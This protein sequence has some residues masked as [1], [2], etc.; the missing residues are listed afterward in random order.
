LGGDVL[1]RLERGLRGAYER[2]SSLGVIVG[3]VSRYGEVRVQHGAR[4]EFEVDPEVYYSGGPSSLHRVGDYLVVVDPK[5]GHAALLRVVEIVRRD[6]LAELGVEP[7]VSGY[8][9]ALEPRG[10]LTRTTIVGELLVEMDPETGEVVPA[11]TSIEPQAPVVDPKPEVLARLLDLPA[12]GVPL[13]ALATPGSLVKG[14]SVPVRLPLK[15][16]LQH[17][18][19]LGTTG[20]GKTTLLKNMIASLYSLQARSARPVVV[21]ADMN[22]DF[23]QLP[24]PPR[25]VEE[26]PQAEAVVRSRIYRGV[27]PPRALH[28]VVPVTIYDVEEAMANVEDPYDQ[29]SLWSWFAS[30]YYRYSILPL[31]GVEPGPWRLKARGGAVAL[32]SEVPAGFRLRLVP[33]SIDT[34][35]MESDR[36][37][38]LM[39]GLTPFARELLR[40][41][42]ERVRRKLDGYA[43][44]LQAL[45]VAATVEL[46]YTLSRGRID[47]EE[48]I[49]GAHEMLSPYIA[50]PA[51]KGVAEAYEEPVYTAPSGEDFT[52]G[53]LARLY[54][55]ELRRVRPHKGTL[56]AL[57]RRLGS[58]LDTGM[59]DLLVD[60]GGKLEPLPEPGWE[61]IVSE[62]ME[63]DA[64]VVLDLKWP[65]ERGLSS[66]EAPRLAAYRMLESL[67][68]WKHRAWAR[69]R[70]TPSV[71]VFID[72][73]HQF[74]PQEK[75]P[76]EE[77]ESSRQVAGMISRIARLG[78][79][80]GL[81]IVFSTHSPKDLHDIILQL[82]NTKIILRMDKGQLDY[83][84]LPEDIKKYLPRL[85]DRTMVIASHVYKEG[86]IM[87]KTSLPLVMHYDYTAQL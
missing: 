45:Y 27:G 39:P 87:A 7:P 74:F 28:V 8:Q 22:Q 58:L 18:L 15:A 31:A 52:L 26:E 55:E 10:L 65:S 69:R 2:A 30:A 61:W 85:P 48:E 59:V 13:G 38:G 6:E 53:D 54:H 84:D 68:E 72:E 46:E 41:V 73:A 36:L 24:L 49:A 60:T 71:V 83:I 12:E 23:L 33:Y 57:Q 80:R 16:F 56:E 63:A 67:I 21:V 44:P 20:S 19:V 70:R 66:V 86:Y 82:A 62:A 5:W 79:A 14:G 25:P 35:R 75:G 32:D 9:Q 76:S 34:S 37:V 78:R 64:P 4:V 17:V 42:R 11:T 29:A 40:R 77:R 1:D 3:S 81:G 50:V 43:G 47:V 51:G